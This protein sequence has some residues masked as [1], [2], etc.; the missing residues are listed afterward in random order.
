MGFGPINLWNLPKQL[1]D[2]QMTERME[3]LKTILGRKFDGEKPDW[4]L[5]PSIE[6]TLEPVIRVLEFGAGLY[7]R[8]NWQHVAEPRR[9]YRNAAMRHLSAMH[10]GHWLDEDSGLPHAAHAICCLMFL[11]WFGE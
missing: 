5:L 8:D 6:R 4:S 3:T 1:R 7:S 11:L 10:D 2:Y 9:R